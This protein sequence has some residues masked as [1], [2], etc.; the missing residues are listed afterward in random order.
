ME[1]MRNEI[2]SISAPQLNDDSIAKFEYREYESTNPTALASQQFISIDILNQDQFLLPS[3]GFIIIEGTIASSDAKKA[4]TKTTDIALAN[5]A[6]LFLFTNM[7]YLLNNQVVESISNPGQT[8]TMIDALRLDKANRLDQCWAKDTSAT[9]A[10]SSGHTTRKGLLMVAPKTPGTFS[11]KIPLNKIFGFAHDYRKVM[12]GLKHSLRF[13][14]TSNDNAVVRGDVVDDAQ[15]TLTKFAVYIPHVEPSLFYKNELTKLIESRKK[16]SVG[17][18]SIKADSFG[19]TQS[20]FF[21]WTITVGS[22]TEKP[23]YVILA[24]Q[25]DKNNDQTKNPAIFDSADISSVQVRV[26]SDHYPVYGHQH[27]DFD[28]MKF[29]LGYHEFQAFKQNF[30]GDEN[31]STVTPLEF[32]DIYPIHVVDIRHRSEQ[33]KLTSHD[34]AIKCTFNK[35]P[36]ANT[37]AYAVLI[38]DKLLSLESTGNH[39]NVII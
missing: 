11:F 31:L 14:R 30:Y 36:P 7:K 15:L 21:N 25:T 35:A 34:I 37:T 13:E 22:G 6:P 20:T 12:Y 16:L 19:V 26:N 3:S 1:D 29:A 5:N 9:A 17:Y 33:L 39:F 28:E 10:S 38:H 18:R 24:F 8:I 32:K 4:Y 27:Y 2:L 23:L